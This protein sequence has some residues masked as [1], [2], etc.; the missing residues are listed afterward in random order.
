MKCSVSTP[1]YLCFCCE[2]R[3]SSEWAIDDFPSTTPRTSRSS[4]ERCLS[5]PYSLV[6]RAFVVLSGGPRSG[7]RDEAGIR[8]ERGRHLT[9][10]LTGSAMRARVLR[11]RHLQR[12][13]ASSRLDRGHRCSG[14]RDAITDGGNVRSSAQRNG[15]DCFGKKRCGVVGSRHHGAVRLKSDRESVSAR[16]ASR[17]RRAAAADAER[18]PHGPR[19]D[20]NRSDV[21]ERVRGCDR[22]GMER[23][24]APAR[25]S[26]RISDERSMT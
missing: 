25:H 18:R 22:G 19:R 2:P 7:L 26:P 4:A 15:Q 16:R 17:P 10:L 20:R 14:G 11:D 8:T 13:P 5:G 12:A 1:A 24:R 3:R 6:I 21:A 23:A 9:C